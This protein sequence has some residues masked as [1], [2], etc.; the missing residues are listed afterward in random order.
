LKDP[1]HS[2]SK[3]FS[4]SEF[5]ESSPG[6]SDNETSNTRYEEDVIDVQTDDDD[7]DKPATVPNAP[8]YPPRFIDTIREPFNLSLNFGDDEN[9]WK[10]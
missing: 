7:W 4:E 5:G 1:S 10:S 6:D 2:I 9:P 3:D 8:T